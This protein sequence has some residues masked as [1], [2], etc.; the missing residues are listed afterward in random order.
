MRILNWLFLQFL[1]FL[2]IRGLKKIDKIILEN[3]MFIN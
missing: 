2:I 3:L 1:Q